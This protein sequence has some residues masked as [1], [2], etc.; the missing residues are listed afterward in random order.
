MVI[1]HLLNGMIL[2]VD[3]DAPLPASPPNIKK[4]RP[5]KNERVNCQD[6]TRSA[7]TFKSPIQTNGR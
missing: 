5:E 2:Q 6:S 4:L 3:I 7:A 1:N